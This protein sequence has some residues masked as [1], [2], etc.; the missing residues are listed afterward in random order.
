[1]DMTKEKS[2][3]DEISQE[4]I[5]EKGP[6]LQLTRKSMQSLDSLIEKHQES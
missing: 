1:M 6:E 4:D 5:P 2:E 3:I